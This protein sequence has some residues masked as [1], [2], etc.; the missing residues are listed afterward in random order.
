MNLTVD[1]EFK[2]WITP[3]E[4]NELSQLEANILADGCRDPLVIWAGT[5]IDGHNR[6]LICTKHNLPFRIVEKD[7]SDR[8]AALNWI[9]DNQL[10][11]RNLSPFQMS[12]LRGKRYNAEKKEYGGDRKSSSQNDNL[13][14]R[15]VEHL[16]KQYSVSPATIARDGATA[17]VAEVVAR[18]KS[19]PLMLLT[20]SQ[21]LEK[22]KEIQA[23]KRDQRRAE[24][25]AIITSAP[26]PLED[27]G[28]F[29]VIYCDPPWKYD[30]SAS[31]SRD[32]ENQYPTMELS[33]ICALPIKDICADSCV[34]FMWVTSPK[35]KEA[36]SV[37]DEWGF[38]YKTCMVWVKDK[39][40]MG[41]YARQQHELILI[42]TRGEL[43]T[44]EP[45]NR[46]SSVFYGERTQHSRKPES[47]Y[48]MLEKMYPEFSKVEL[49]SRS[50]RNGWKVWGNQT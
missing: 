44:P 38:V 36:M 48:E 34:L 37:L 32:I 42:A 6:Y 3:L 28:V 12:L 24:R 43:P 21:V 7:F 14:E 1:A 41:Y 35:L 29:N 25:V 49:F 4:A 11:R 5:I 45:E 26:A 47:V 27:I 39:I 17:R 18:E 8:T 23:E 31:T 19:V 20:K 30:Y 13:K 22:A 33:E 9:I 46:P 40:G 2:S 10:G 16:A 15:T 50:P